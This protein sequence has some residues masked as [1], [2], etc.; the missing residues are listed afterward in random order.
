MRKCWDF[1]MLYLYNMKYDYTFI[2][3]VFNRPKEIEELL[4]S[5]S[6]QLVNFVFEVTIIEDGSLLTCEEVVCK[7][8][9]KLLIN[10]LA[11]ANS[12]PGDSRNYGM[13]H[14][15]GN[16]FI[17]LDSDVILPPDYLNNVDNFLKKNRLQCYGGPDLAHPSF[18]KLQKAID[19]CM[20][21][22]LT[23]GGIRG[24]RNQ[25]QKYEPRSFNMGLSKKL[26]IETGGFT[27]I[28]PGE[29]PDLS[30]RIQKLGYQTVF[31]P[32]AGLYHKRRISWK[33][34]YQQVYKFGLVRPI[35]FKKHPSTIKISY[36]FPSVFS[37]FLVLSSLLL[38]LGYYQFMVL[39]FIYFFFLV[40][41]SWLRHHSIVI[42]IY[43]V[44]AAILQFFGYGLGFLKSIL[45]I[46][47]FN[48]K[49]QKVF[50]YLFYK[51]KHQF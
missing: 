47:V 14:S 33:K 44:A 29:D 32:D 31:L 21:S 49:P 17:I 8:E 27:N 48:K 38:A 30:I 28:H 23:T 26:F 12:G 36:F 13:L 50:P 4:E 1:F 41:G 16:F 45:Y 18:T 22:F 40:L 7:Y 39:Y 24:S 5:I 37:F 6:K 15:N 10:Y 2:I 25:I 42:S 34:F 51:G 3:P 35:L 43:V 9:T 11:K 20:T 46:H 19:Y